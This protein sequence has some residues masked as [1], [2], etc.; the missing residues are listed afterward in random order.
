M[1]P[2][3]A[4]GE[5]LDARAD[6]YAVGVMLF[7][8]VVGQLPFQASSPFA[9]A[10]LHLSAPPP[11]PGELRPDIG[12]F[13]PLESL[14]LRVLSKNKAE[15]PSSAE[16]FR[17]DLLQIERDYHSPGWQQAA[18][19]E[20]ATLQPAG[21]AGFRAAKAKRLGVAAGLVGL[22]AAGVFG[23]S[24]S[25]PSAR[26]GTQTAT[27]AL[28]AA[29]APPAPPALA[30]SPAAPAATEESS[31]IRPAPRRA[32]RKPLRPHARAAPAPLA[33]A[34]DAEP[35]LQAAEERL[36][37]GHIA[38]AC[39]LGQTVAARLPNEPAIWEFL[40]R[41]YMRLPD[42]RQGRACYRKYLA[43]APA[44]PKASFIRAIVEQERP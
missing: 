29:P 16:V 34:A 7:Q 2:E 27:P 26:P 14:I 41:C 17:A 20:A 9:L 36:S 40:G 6:V 3:Q 39:L 24:R 44:S 19:R 13:P 15:R 11:R 33:N 4:R 28:V 30:A 5:T 1:A 31:S 18:G 10:S 21:D 37:A 8:A 12:F 23:A 32:D 25:A 35:S 42:P 38:E 22:F 43:L